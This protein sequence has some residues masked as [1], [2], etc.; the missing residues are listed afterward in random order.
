MCDTLMQM[1]RWFGYRPGYLGL[2]RL[3]STP[4][5]EDWFQHIAEASEELQRE[6][7]R[8]VA[9]G[10]TRRD[11]GLKVRS[12]PVLMV[13]SRVK[14]RHWTTVPESLA[15]DACVP[16]YVDQRSDHASLPVHSEHQAVR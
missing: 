13:T 7:D 14:K 11:Y 3:Y 2:C 10:G 4:D 5:L 8:M 1:G 16:S 15:R 6:F 12:H 9:V